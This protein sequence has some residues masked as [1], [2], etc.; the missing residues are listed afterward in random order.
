MAHDKKGKGRA[1]TP[2]IESPVSSDF[3]ETRE[4]TPPRALA[5]RKAVA[6]KVPKRAHGRGRPNP[7]AHARTRMKRASVPGAHGDD[8]DLSYLEHRIIR[9]A[10]PMNRTGA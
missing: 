8:N 1:S 2:E 9:M 6:T 3:E 5:K 10:Q 7:D 4:D